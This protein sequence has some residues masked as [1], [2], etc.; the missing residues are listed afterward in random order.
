MSKIYA[1][2]D[3]HAY[4]D[5]FERSLEVVDLSGDN[6]LILL[7]DYIHGGGQPCE[8][9]DKIIELQRKYGQDK[10]IA[11]LGNHDEMFLS[12]YSSLDDD[13]PN[14]NGDKYVSFLSSLPLYYETDFDQVFCHAG[15]DEEAEEDW[16]Y[17]TTDI[18]FTEKYPASV[19]SAN[20]RKF[21]VDIISGHIG[22]AEIYKDYTGDNSRYEIFSDGSHYYIDGTVGESGVIPVLCFDTDSRTYYDMTYG[23]PVPIMKWWEEA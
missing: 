14:I 17:E 22:T 11:L 5:S 16:E 4:Y 2:S 10:V 3:I 21:C 23:N 1:M 7:G 12:G 15:I 8:V 19:F 6:K 20:D 18:C 9:L 13:N